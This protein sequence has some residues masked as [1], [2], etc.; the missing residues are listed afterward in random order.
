MVA[1]FRHRLIALG[2]LL[3][4][5]AS[6]LLALPRLRAAAHYV[7]SINPTWVIGASRSSWRRPK[8]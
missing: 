8:R 3:L 4:A 2:A 6:A 5:G 7:S 1:V